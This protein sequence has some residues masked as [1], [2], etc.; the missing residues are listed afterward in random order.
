[1]FASRPLSLQHRWASRTPNTSSN[2]SLVKCDPSWRSTHLRLPSQH[3]LGVH[4]ECRRWYE[5]PSAKSSLPRRSLLPISTNISTLHLWVGPINDRRWRPGVGTEM[6]ESEHVY[7]LLDG[8][9]GAVLL[10]SSICEGRDWASIQ[11]WRDVLG[12]GGSRWVWRPCNG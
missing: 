1:M 9:G 6:V 3:N 2:T 7:I 12:L 5:R 4:G 8:S 10:S 11:W